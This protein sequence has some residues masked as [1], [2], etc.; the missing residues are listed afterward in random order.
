METYLRP[1]FLNSLGVVLQGFGTI[2]G[3][4]AVCY[5]GYVGSST[6]NK[7]RTQ[8][9]EER[10]IEEAEKIVVAAY[11]AR[12]YLSYLRSPYIA[13]QELAEAERQ[14][15]TSG[16]ELSNDP[17][18]R[19]RLISTQV[20]YRRLEASHDKIMDLDARFPM[21]RALFGDALEGALE[22]LGAQFNVLKAFV[23]S[24]AQ[25][26][27]ATDD[28][29]FGKKIQSALVRG[30][31]TEDKDEIARTV[32]DQIKIIESLCLPVL[33]LVAGKS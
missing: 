30:Y 13:P 9:L 7:W 28:I 14:L 4:L 32:D 15:V 2:L 1:E 18:Q 17:S 12:R 16:F 24:H 22:K 19:K 11:N 20:Y 23:D 29:E 3:A 31:P 10:K 21:A 5:A 8:K 25:F 26:N 6:I 33:R 27:P